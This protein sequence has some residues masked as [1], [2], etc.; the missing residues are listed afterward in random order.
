V[1]AI[2]R[3]FVA[4]VP[5]PAVLT[6]IE[7]MVE[8]ARAPDDGLRWSRPDQRHLTVQFLG[9][10]AELDSL[11]ESLDESLRRVAPFAVQFGAGG[12]FPAPKRASV[13]WLGV[14]TG[15]A[16]LDAL[17]AAVTG[18]TAPLGF[19]TEDRPFQ[20]HLT[21]ARA[22]RPRDRRALVD[23]LGTGPAGPRWTVDRAVL[24]ESE[25]R[26]DGAIH[27]DRHAFPLGGR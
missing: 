23:R 26:A 24:F 3:A 11:T 2:A 4:V 25:T 9:R 10:V 14:S 27:T 16:E 13:V 1:T 8:S 21:L 20:P 12:A 5:P 22:P 19:A 17:A 18:A 6:A 7:S 15:A